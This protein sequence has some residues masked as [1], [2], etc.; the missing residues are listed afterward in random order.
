MMIEFKQGE[1]LAVLAKKGLAFQALIVKA[2]AVREVE[3]LQSEDVGIIKL[4]NA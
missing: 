1:A 2:D 3:L 4:R